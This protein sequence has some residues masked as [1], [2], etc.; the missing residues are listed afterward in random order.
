MLLG[1]ILLREGKCSEGDIMAA[2]TRQT[3]GDGRT[4]GDILVEMGTIRPD[5]LTIALVKKRK[6]LIAAKGLLLANKLG[7]RQLLN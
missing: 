4:I 6:T 7:R 2:M 1:Q 3:T 5:D